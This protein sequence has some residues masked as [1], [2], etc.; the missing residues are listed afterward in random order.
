MRACLFPLAFI[1]ITICCCQNHKTV[2]LED[3]LADVLASGEKTELKAITDFDWDKMIVLEPYAT[4]D[5]SS[6]KSIPDEAKSSIRSL[7]LFDSWSVLLFT[8]NDEYVAHSE[9]KVSTTDNLGLRNGTYT[10]EMVIPIEKT[11]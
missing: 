7:D 11:E 3:K 2:N 4:F 9:V 6:I 1:S 8:L 10:P 5:S